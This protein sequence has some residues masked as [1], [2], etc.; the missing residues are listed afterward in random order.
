MAKSNLPTEKS[1]IRTLRRPEE[2]DFGKI[3]NLPNSSLPKRKQ[4]FFLSIQY[5]VSLE[6]RPGERKIAIYLYT[7]I[8][9]ERGVK[10]FTQNVTEEE[11]AL[12]V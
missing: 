8:T 1:C 6:P 3:K 11:S 2:Y 12:S 4:N 10:Q 9:S 7:T 5:R